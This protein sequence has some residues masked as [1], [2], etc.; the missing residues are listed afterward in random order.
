MAQSEDCIR[1]KL[2]GERLFSEASKLIFA[3]EDEADERTF[4]VRMR[5]SESTEEQL[6]RDKSTSLS[7][8][9]SSNGPGRMLSATPCF[10]SSFSS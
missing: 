8:S 10:G 9:R 4:D 1:A 6:L 5:N 2:H 3:T 7:L